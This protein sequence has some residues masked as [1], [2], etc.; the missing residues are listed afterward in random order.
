MKDLLK[1]NGVK[2]T[3]PDNLSIKEED[4]MSRESIR[5][6]NSIKAAMSGRFAK[7]QLSRSISRRF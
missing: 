6:R 3:K 7:G 2:I 1:H 4:K 5:L